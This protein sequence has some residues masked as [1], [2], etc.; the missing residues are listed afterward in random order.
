MREGERER[1]RERVRERVGVGLF[2][3]FYFSQG[4]LHVYFGF[5]TRATDFL[6]T[7]F[8]FLIYAH[9]G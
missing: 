7:I 9:I 4:I 6:E 2:S 5:L 8:I 3:L 1:E